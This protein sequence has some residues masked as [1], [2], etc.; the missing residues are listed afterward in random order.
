MLRELG[1]QNQRASSLIRLAK[2][3][4]DKFNGDVPSNM[5]SLL[6]IP[7]VGLYTAAAVCCFA[8]GKNVPVVDANVLRV[9]DR[10]TGRRHGR[11]LRRSV[12][13]WALAWAI[14][15]KN[16][17]ARHNYA[18]LDFAATYCGKKPKC[19]RCPLRR[20]CSFGVSLIGK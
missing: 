17:C 7:G 13:A 9:F 16:D 20:K 4:L 18:I 14:L 11:D 10:I 2:V 6:S 5:Q 19:E 12:D 15:P 8:F 1:L 3:L